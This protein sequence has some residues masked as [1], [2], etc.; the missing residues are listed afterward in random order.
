MYCHEAARCR[1]INNALSQTLG[2]DAEIILKRFENTSKLRCQGYR[3]N[4]H[5][6]TISGLSLAVIV[7]SIFEAGK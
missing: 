3:N 1:T 7:L 2:D 4:C 5:R 6:G